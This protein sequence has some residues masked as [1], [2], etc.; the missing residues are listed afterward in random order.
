MAGM[1]EKEE[2]NNPLLMYCLLLFPFN[3]IFNH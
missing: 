2:G 3:Q 1:Q